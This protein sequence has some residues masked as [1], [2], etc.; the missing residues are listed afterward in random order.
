MA[1]YPKQRLKIVQTKFRKLKKIQV[2][3][4]GI[5]MHWSRSCISS[6]GVF[7]TFN[8]IL[9]KQEKKMKIYAMH[10]KLDNANRPHC[11]LFLAFRYCD[12]PHSVVIN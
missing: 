8:L 11:Q 12:Y 3:Q 2:R 10:T 5:N 4:Y 1:M 9:I 6:G 7:W